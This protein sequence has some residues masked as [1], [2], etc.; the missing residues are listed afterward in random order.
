MSQCF[1]EDLLGPENLHENSDNLEPF[2]ESSSSIGSPEFF[3]F[4]TNGQTPAFLAKLW[5]MVSQYGSLARWNGDGTR[6]VI[7]Q[8][9]TK[10]LKHFFKHDKISSFIRQLNM[11]GFNKVH[12][13]PSNSNLIH[14]QNDNFVR[15]NPEKMRFIRRKAKKLGNS[16][17][18][19]ASSKLK[20]SN[21]EIE[22]RLTKVED[23][24]GIVKNQFDGMVSFM[25][26][27]LQSARPQISEDVFYHRKRPIGNSEIQ[28]ITNGEPEPKTYRSDRCN[29]RF[30]NYKN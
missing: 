22:N 28:M 4:P 14:F 23:E 26:H 13:D 9:N 21:K 29:G 12:T 3:E 1:L 5:Q 15:E 6:V 19:Q 24:V 10:S 2:V 11:Y 27:F 7:D 17:S 18:T 20:I 25:V 16:N 30:P 8:T